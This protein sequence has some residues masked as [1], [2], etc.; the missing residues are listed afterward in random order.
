MMRRNPTLEAAILA[1]PDDLATRLV[2][3]DWFQEQGDPIGAWVA[4]RARME[5]VPEDLILR[6]AAIEYQGDHQDELFGDAM[7]A[8]RRAYIGWRGGFVDELRLRRDDGMTPEALAALF[9]HPLVQFVRHIAIGELTLDTAAVI[10]A[11]VAARLPLLEELVVVDG[12]VVASSVQIDAIAELPLRRLTLSNVTVGAAMPTLRDLF[13]LFLVDHQIA[14]A[15]TACPNLERLTAIEPFRVQAPVLSHG[16]LERYDSTKLYG[17]PADVEYNP[18]EELVRRGD[19]ATIRM[20][21]AAGSPIYNLGTTYLRERKFADATLFLDLA[22]TLPF[23]DAKN[24]MNAAIAHEHAGVPVQAELFAR[25]GLLVSPGDEGFYE[26]LIDALRQQGRYDD[27]LRLFPKAKAAIA[28]PLQLDFDEH[29]DR[30]C[31]LDLVLTLIRAGKVD[32]AIALVQELPDK[33][34]DRHH[35][36]LAIAY[37]QRGDVAQAHAEWSAVSA[38]SENGEGVVH[39][40]RALFALEAGDVIEAWAAVAAAVRA[41]YTDLPWLI[42]DARLESLLQTLPRDEDG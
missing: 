38:K 26:V 32:D 18:I 30:A 34:D 13:A 3:G 4:I 24:I 20:L 28:N 16:V 1:A 5:A 8:V 2:Y 7:L 10:D 35:A 42:A 39:H 9:A 22:A 12:V 11:L 37:L 27:A 25:E 40:A 17:M 15:A 21:P 19:R 41:K 36:A 14:W 23:G 6:G 33:I 29:R 31:L